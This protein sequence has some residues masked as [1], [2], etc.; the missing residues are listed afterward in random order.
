MALIPNYSDNFL[1]ISLDGVTD[2]DCETD[3]VGLGMP[4]NAPSGL[5]IRKI[6]FHPSFR[7]DILIVRDGEN[8]PMMFGG[9]ALGTYDRLKEDYREDGKVDRGKLMSPYIHANE[10]TITTANQAYVVF[11]I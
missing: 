10:C 2:F 11:E 3:L 9:E 7:G 1:E 6:V 4:K 8:G 5:R